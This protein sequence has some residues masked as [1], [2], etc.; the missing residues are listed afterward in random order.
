[1]ISIC[2][3]WLLV[4]SWELSRFQVDLIQTKT[5]D[6]KHDVGRTALA[7]PLLASGCL[8]CNLG[9]LRFSLNVLLELQ[10]APTSVPAADPE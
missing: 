8:K 4:V 10:V 2:L 7:S 6:V 5:V 1:M 9:E 3:F